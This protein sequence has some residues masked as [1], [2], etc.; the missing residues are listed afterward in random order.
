MTINSYYAGRYAP[1]QL[2]H[3]CTELDRIKKQGLRED[4]AYVFSDDA[5]KTL[6]TDSAVTSHTCRRI[7]G[8]QLCTSPGPG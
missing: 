1:D 3:F 6:T 2:V 7:D 5:F 8:F 4:T